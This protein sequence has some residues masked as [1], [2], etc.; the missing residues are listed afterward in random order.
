MFGQFT[1]EN[2]SAETPRF[3]LL[4]S[5]QAPEIRHLLVFYLNRAC[6]KIILEHFEHLQVLLK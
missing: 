3:D 6:G 1:Y 2:V 4:Q 5:N